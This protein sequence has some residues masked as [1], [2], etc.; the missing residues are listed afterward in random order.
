LRTG[1]FVLLVSLALASSFPA[2]STMTIAQETPVN[3]SGNQL[4]IAFQAV[5]KA[6]SL[7]A[8]ADQVAKLSAQLNNALGYYNTA[9]ELAAQGNPTASE[10]FQLSN[11]TSTVVIAK[12]LILQS[13]AENSR[14]N[15]L[16]T[17]YITAIVAATMSALLVLEYHQIPNFLRKRK[18]LNT[19]LRL[20]DSNETQG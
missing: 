17:A 12:A 15:E 9:V 6:D 4:I 2:A 3:G 16:L 13:D 10:Y 11:Q 7:G 5:Q 1:L 14:R 8:P 20:R 19:K 18:L